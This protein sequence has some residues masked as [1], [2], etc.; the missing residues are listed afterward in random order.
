[1]ASLKQTLETLRIK[2]WKLEQKVDHQKKEIIREII[3]IRE[4]HSLNKTVDTRLY[5]KADKTITY[6]KS[7]VNAHT[8]SSFSKSSIAIIRR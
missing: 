2:V 5:G 1:M 7:D 6:K 4:I 8:S 3:K